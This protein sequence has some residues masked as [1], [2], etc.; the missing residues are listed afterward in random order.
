VTDKQA[1]KKGGRPKGSR[2]LTPELQERFIDALKTGG[3]I[4]DAAAYTGIGA[5]TAFNWLDRGR[6]ERER[7]TAFPDAKP[8]PVETPFVDFLEAVET[9]R[10]ATQLRAIAQIQK[11]AADGTW[12]AAAWYL[13]RSAPGKWS[14]KDRTEITGDGGGAVK[15]DIAVDELEKKI[16]R[17]MQKREETTG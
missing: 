17:I 1:P 16:A 6:K 3:Y 5:A 10:A 15:V 7:L 9:A 12:Q 4:D 2:L 13:E 8:D 11:A 14:R